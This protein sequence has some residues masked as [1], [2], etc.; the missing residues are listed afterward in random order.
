[1]A[2]DAKGVG[3][4]TAENI[5]AVLR[6]LPETD[7]T[8]QQVMEQAREYGSDVSKA[9]LGKW[10]SSGRADIRAGKRQT[11]YA[12]FAQQFDRIKAE[13]CTP[14]AGRNREFDRALQ[15]LEMT[16]DCGND[17]MTLA[18]GTLADT[19]RECQDIDGQGR[20]R[21]RRSDR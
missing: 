17:K 18:D 4:F 8:Y 7:G 19:C 16:C 1:M 20:P 14:D 11:A 10:V 15:I 12:R 5:A 2:N 3:H 13:H 21:R 9:T 6:A